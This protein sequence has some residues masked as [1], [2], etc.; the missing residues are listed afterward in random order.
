MM[1][2]LF[3]IGSLLIIVSGT[4]ASVDETAAMMHLLPRDLIASLNGTDE[5]ADSHSQTEGPE[6][7]RISDLWKLMR[8]VSADIGLEA[9]ART[10]PIVITHPQRAMVL[11]ETRGTVSKLYETV[12]KTK[13]IKGCCS[14]DIAIVF[15]GAILLNNHRTITK[16]GIN[17]VFNE[18]QL[19]QKPLFVSLL[20]MV[21]EI[22]N[23]ENIPWIEWAMHCLSD[24]S[25]KQQKSALPTGRGLICDESGKLIGIDLSHLNLIGTIHLEALPQTVRSLDLSF[26]DFESLNL[27]G[28]RGKSLEKLYVESNVRFQVTTDW[29]DGE[30]EVNRPHRTLVLSLSRPRV[31]QLPDTR[32]KIRQWLQRQRIFEVLVLDGIAIK[33]TESLPFYMAMLN[34][35]DRVTNKDRIPWYQHM[36]NGWTILPEDRQIF[37]LKHKSRCRYSLDLRGL[38]LEGHID[39]TALPRSIVQVDLS[40]NNLSGVLFFGEYGLVPINLRDL[41][42]QNNNKL[43][44]DLRQLNPITHL[45]RLHISSNQLK[46]PS[47][48]FLRSWL[49]T[50]RIK[51]VY[52]DEHEVMNQRFNFTK[53][54]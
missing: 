17:E 49:N 50:S 7:P 36:R 44:I 54:Q 31:Y 14:R 43:R 40:N 15:E 29:F 19:I 41:N 47:L 13:M 45:A 23:K 11:F 38:G 12:A 30:S 24:S 39:L 48:T 27:D 21:T 1:L 42:L 32:S 8:S 26:N 4:N 51:K 52:F 20:E 6:L 46:K 2:R 3:F 28:L 33:R 34:V 18:I 9:S 22:K 53:N 37:G 25:A 16:I 5:A 35:V 10:I